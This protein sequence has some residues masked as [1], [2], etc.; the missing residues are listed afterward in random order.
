MSKKKGGK[1]A[2]ERW[3]QRTTE[4]LE[5]LIAQGVGHPLASAIKPGV[6]VRP[7]NGL[8][9]RWYEGG[10]LLWLHF[11]SLVESFAEHRW[12]TYR[13]ARK[14]DAQVRKGER[15][16]MILIWKPLPPR[17]ESNDD[18]DDTDE[19]ERRG[20]FGSATVFNASQID[21]L[22][23][24]ELDAPDLSAAEQAAD[25][26]IKATGVD[27]RVSEVTGR[28]ELGS[29]DYRSDYVTVRPRDHFIS[30][31]EYY[32]VVFHEL[33]H[34][35][36]AKQRLDRSLSGDRE[37]LAYAQEELIAEL[38]AFTLSTTF[39]LGFEPPRSAEYIDYYYNKPGFHGK[40]ADDPATWQ[41]AAAASS[42]VCRFLC[43]LADPDGRLLPRQ[44]APPLPTVEEADD[45]YA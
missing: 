29:Y 2:Y 23:S 7:Y 30:N 43:E 17:D 11:A 9:G 10:N 15:G 8:T 41:Q 32:S 24:V 27:L 38:T 28:G 6:P 21:G 3:T 12:L 13:Q 35:S 1:T 25:A 39:G 37:T 31:A 34:W 26:F 18:T 45:G 42:K 14:V 5:E 44:A 16:T 36:G 20:Y 40:P 22:P 4:T 19:R 33:A